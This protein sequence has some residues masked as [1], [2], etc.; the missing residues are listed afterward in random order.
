MAE[1]LPICFISNIYFWAW[2]AYYTTYSTVCCITR[3][4]TTN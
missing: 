1:A 3:L 2:V 4:G